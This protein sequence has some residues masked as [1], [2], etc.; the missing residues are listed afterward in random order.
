[1]LVSLYLG[2]EKAIDVSNGKATWVDLLRSNRVKQLVDW[3]SVPMARTR[4][5]TDR[6]EAEANLEPSGDQA[7]AKTQFK[8]P[9]PV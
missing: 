7:T 8:W 9:G 5:S 3:G 6:Q 4:R 1:M 2:V